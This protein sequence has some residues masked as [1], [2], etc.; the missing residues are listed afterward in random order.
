ML[1]EIWNREWRAGK[2]KVEW[3][4]FEPFEEES[5]RR[6]AA[7]T[8][9]TNVSRAALSNARRARA[10]LVPRCCLA[11]AQNYAFM[12]ILA[13]LITLFIAHLFPSLFSPRYYDFQSLC[14]RI[15]QPTPSEMNPCGLPLLND[16]AVHHPHTNLQ[17]ILRIR[18]CQKRSSMETHLACTSL[19]FPSTQ[20]KH[21]KFRYPIHR[22]RKL[23]IYLPHP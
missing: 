9:R 4:F 22:L 13:P 8:T 1:L 10:S 11:S 6:M 5:R 2:F 20:R 14:P 18:V 21:H 7:G 12:S 3:R 15:H 16:I 23:S 19:A 17:L